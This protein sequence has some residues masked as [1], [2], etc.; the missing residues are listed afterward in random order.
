MTLSARGLDETE[1]QLTR[2]GREMTVRVHEFHAGRDSGTLLVFGEIADGCL[3]RIHSRCLYGDA[4]ASDDCDCGPELDLA[5]DQI[6]NEG[7]GVLLYLEQEGRG[8]G[9]TAKARGLRASELTGEDTFTSYAQLGL[10]ADSRDYG[11]GIEQLVQ[12]GLRRIRLLTNN[13]EKADAVRAAGIHVV[14]LPLATRARS[15]RARSYLDAKRQHRKHWFAADA[16][17]WAPTLAS[18]ESTLVMPVLPDD[19]SWSEPAEEPRK[20]RRLR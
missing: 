18:P 11:P 16:G 14:V 10:P 15:A 2:K 19:S 3:V 8:A 20:R 6:Q 12:L 4:L 9:L 5:M 7:A 1:H 13:P 17:P